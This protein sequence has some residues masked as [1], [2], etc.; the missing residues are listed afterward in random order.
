MVHQAK[1]KVLLMGLGAVGAG[2]ARSLADRRDVEIVAA[3][4]THPA[5]AGKDLGEVVGLGRP[6]GVQ[7]AY[8]PDAVLAQADASTVLHTTD[9]G[10]T[11]VYQ[12]IIGC[13]D[14]GKNVISNCEELTFPW[15][16]YPELAERLDEH[17]RRAGVCVLG[18]SVN[19]GFIMDTLPVLLTVACERVASLRVK[20]VAD[21]SPDRLDV[22]TRCGIGLSPQGFQRAASE[23]AIGYAG[24]RESAFMVADT[25]GWHLDEVSESIEPVMAAGRVRTPYFSVEKGCVTGLKQQLVGLSGGREVLRLEVEVSLGTKEGRDEIEIDGQPPIRVVVPGG[26]DGEAATAAVMINCLPTIAYSG[27]AGLLSM[28]DMPI[29]PHRGPRFSAVEEILT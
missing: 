11:G 14:A 3:I 22:R 24:L 9:A 8:D 23:G 13:I 26:I 18:A 7:V 29:A 6:V 20:R 25:L 10:L 4:D 17:A 21:A 27:A 16:R 12:Q 5:R 1:I 28:R 19:P 15:A 2:L